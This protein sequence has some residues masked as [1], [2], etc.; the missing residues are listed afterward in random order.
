MKTFTLRRIRW[1]HIA[2]AIGSLITMGALPG[3]GTIV[4]YGEIKAV[5]NL[6]YDARTDLTSEKYTEYKYVGD[7]YDGIKDKEQFVSDLKAA[8]VG[9][10]QVGIHTLNYD[11]NGIAIV[12]YLPQGVYSKIISEFVKPVGAAVVDGNHIGVYCNYTEGQE[13]F[14][15]LPPGTHPYPD[16]MV[17]HWPVGT[18]LYRTLSDGA[19]EAYKAGDPDPAGGAD[20][21]ETKI[22][23]ADL[24]GT[25]LDV[26]YTIDIEFSYD[27]RQI[28]AKKFCDLGD[29][30]KAIQL[31]IGTPLRGKGRVVTADFGLDIDSTTNRAALE[32]KILDMLKLANAGSPAVFTKASL[33]NMEVGTPEYRA[34]L[35]QNAI[36]MEQARARRALLD[37]EAEI[38]NK[39][40]ELKALEAAGW[41]EM[42][43]QLG[44]EGQWECLAVLVNGQ[45]AN[46]Y[47]NQPVPNP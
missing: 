24:A 4:P 8:V 45:D 6:D 23:N 44:C 22:D 47:G 25:D 46:P 43:K 10:A 28:N 35:Q 26:T 27:L 38:I 31:M 13:K 2:L 21:V 19:F 7:D 11:E 3:C 29:P 33:R 40:N 15:I 16:F 42:L 30:A 20:L 9:E 14:L 17:K 37:L 5:R 18:R 12:E 41:A 34:S 36:T 32:Q 1:Y 39:E